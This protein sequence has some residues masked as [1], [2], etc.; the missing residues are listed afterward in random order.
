MTTTSA[1]DALT[2]TTGFQL[3]SK[4]ASTSSTDS[5]NTAAS[6]ADA[7]DRFLKLLV[8]QLNNQDPMNPLDNAQMTSQIAQ[9]NTVTGIQQLNTTVTSLATQ[10]AAMQGIQA[11][12]LVGHQVLSTGNTLSIDSTTKAG[13][14]IFELDAAAANVTVDVTTASGTKLGTVALGPQAA[15][16]HNFSWDATGYSATDGLVFKVNATNTDGSAVTSTSLMQNKVTSIGSDSTGALTLNFDGGGSAAYS[17]VK[18][19]L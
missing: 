17:T 4:T 5:S 19:I 15:G 9:I 3:T 13:S 12:A 8:A 1:T 2:S 18:T 14:G 16:Q 11:S 7:Q 6:P 10:M